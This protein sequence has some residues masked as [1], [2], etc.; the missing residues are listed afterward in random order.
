MKILLLNDTSKTTNWGCKATTDGV[1]K[2]LTSQFHACE[3]HSIELDVIPYRKIKQVGKYRSANIMKGILQN[4]SPDSVRKKLTG[5]GVHFLDDWLAYDRLYLNGEGDIHGKSGH[6]ARL[7]SLLW[8]FKTYGK[9]TA[10][11][12]QSIDFQNNSLQASFLKAVY[13]N[14]DCLTVREPQS[15]EL[16]RAIGIDNAQLV[17]DAAFSIPGCNQISRE[18]N[19]DKRYICLTGS[20]A[21]PRKDESY[22]QRYINIITRHF[23]DNL[24]FL[25]STKT[26]KR[27]A[28]ILQHEYKQL[29][30]VDEKTP[31][32]EIVKILADARLLIGGRFHPSIFAAS[33]GTPFIAIEGNTHKME[34]LIEMLE[35]DIPVCKWRD[36]DAFA[37]TIE[38]VKKRD[39]EKISEHLLAKY[40]ELRSQLQYCM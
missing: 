16:S 14:L 36:I 11:I 29:S 10:A 38:S 7:I 12:N 21:I 37:L 5:L 28:E 20:S 9:Y 34:G 32:Q 27:I 6:A 39:M 31:Y 25:A 35:Y 13:S 18:Q 40:K 2:T 3:I 1:K 33:H 24:V 22:F 4:A 17:P 19:T 30:I 26:D 8:L 23:D 15:L